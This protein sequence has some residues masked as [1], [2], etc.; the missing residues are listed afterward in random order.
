M[1]LVLAMAIA[2]PSQGLAAAGSALCIAFAHHGVLATASPDA[3]RPAHAVPGEGQNPHSV[4]YT[5]CAACGV[6][7]GI[8]APIPV[9]SSFA[10]RP[11]IESVSWPVPAGHVPQRLDRPPLELPA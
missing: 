1:L 8:A 4:H 5:A 7:A 2:V 11:A 10:P 9:S 6:V 3:A